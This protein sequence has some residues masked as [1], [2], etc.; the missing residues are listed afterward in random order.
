MRDRRIDRAALEAVWFGDY[1]LQSVEINLRSAEARIAFSGAQLR[2][3]QGEGGNMS[4]T[5]LINPVLVLIGLRSFASHPP[6]ARPETIV[7]G[8]A[9]GA[10]SSG[11][12]VEF[13]VVG[14]PEPVAVRFECDD[15]WLVA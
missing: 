1:D 9:F 8:W 7:L 4:T 3:A 14:D 6:M 5:E 2:L 11:Y 10:T 15:M 13:M 12:L